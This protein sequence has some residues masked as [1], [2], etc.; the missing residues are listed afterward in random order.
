MKIIVDYN[1]DVVFM[2]KKRKEKEKKKHWIMPL[3]TDI[4]PSF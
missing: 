2:E 1:I 3:K 4:A